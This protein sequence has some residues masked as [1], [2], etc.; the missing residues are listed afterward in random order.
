LAKWQRIARKTGRIIAIAL[1]AALLLLAAIG[2][3]L[4][5]PAVQQMVAGKITQSLAR[6]LQTPFSIRNIEI[7]FF[8][9]ALLEGVYVE[10]LNGDTLLY[11]GR[12]EAQL[13]LFAPFRRQIE[14][15]SISLN[16]SFFN[17]SRSRDSTYNFQFII[18][19]FSS[20]PQDTSQAPSEWEFGIR[21][22]NITATRFALVDSAGRSSLFARVGDCSATIRQ[23]ALPE[24]QIGIGRFSLKNSSFAYAT[25]PGA[26]GP[27]AAENAGTASRLEFPFTGWQLQAG[28]LEAD[29]LSF[30]YD[31]FSRP[32]GP[33]GQFDPAHL[34]LKDIRLDIR[35]FSWKETGLAASLR[36]L[37]LHEMNGFELQQL[38]AGLHVSPSDITLSQLE[39]QTPGSRLAPSSLT[40]RFPEFASLFGPFQEVSAALSLSPSFFAMEDIRYWS[41]P[42]PYLKAGYSGKARLSGQIRGKVNDMVVSGLYGTLDDVFHFQLDGRVKG[43]PDRAG[44]TF[45]ANIREL[46]A[47]QAGIASATEGLPL[48]SG[49]AK[50][51][52]IRLEGYVGGR[53]DSLVARG[54]SI[55]TD[56]YTAFAGQAT[57]LGLPDIQK[58]RFQVDISEMRSQASELSGFMGGTAPP[59]L[60]ALGKMSYRGAFSGTIYDF[61]LA[62][63]LSSGQG[64]LEQDVR[65]HFN[66]AFSNAS[67][68]GRARLAGFG[69]GAILGDTS[70]FGLATMEL[71]GA[72]SGLSL[73][74]LSAKVSATVESITFKQYTYRDIRAGGD[75]LRRRFAG[76]I[77]VDDPHLRFQFDGLADFNDSI[78]NLDF[79]V[80]LDTA[81]L[82]YLNLYPSALRLST[83]LEARLKG[84]SLDNISGFAALRRLAVADEDQHY[85]ADSI[86]L[87]AYAQPGGGKVLAL[88]S[89]IAEA[90]LEGDYHLGELSGLLIEFADGFF[91]AKRLIQSM[92]E[93]DSVVASPQ[94]AGQDFQ[95]SASLSRPARLMR[96]LLPALQVLDTASFQGQFN[97]EN[98]RLQL[99]GQ[100]PRL[101]YSGFQVD[102][103][104]LLVDGAPDGLA[105]RLSFRNLQNEGQELLPYGEAGIRMFQDSLLFKLDI[106]DDTSGQKLGLQGVVAAPGER[107]HLKLLGPMVLNGFDWGIPENNDI[108]FAPA[109]LN[110]QGLKFTRDEQQ[111]QIQSRGTGAEEDFAPIDIFFDEFRLVELSRLAGLDENFL[112][113]ALN[114]KASLSRPDTTYEYEARLEIRQMMLDSQLL[115]NLALHAVPDVN[116]QEL[117]LDVQLSGPGNAFSLAGS[118]GMQDKQLGF[119]LK[120][121]RL[122]M[123]LADL[124][125]GGFA[126]D[127]RGALSGALEIGGTAGKPVVTGAISLDSVSTFVEYLQSRY[128]IPKHTIHLREK[129]IDIGK[130]ELL[131]PSNRKAALSGQAT[132][133]HFDE[134]GLNLQFSAPAFQVL[135]TGPGDNELFYGKILVSIDARI[136]GPLSSPAIEVN[137]QTL[138]GT[139]LT[140]LP[141]SEEEAITQEDF[142]L[143]GKP[144]AEAGDTAQTQVYRTAVSGYELN[145]QLTLTPDAEL[146]AIIDPATGDKLT[147]RGRANLAVEMDKS[148]LL[149]TTGD[150]Y[151][152]GGSYFFNYEGLVKRTFQIREGSHI[153]LP[154]DPLEARFGITAQYTARTSAYELI[155]RQSDLSAEEANAA[156][157]RMDVQVIM[158]LEGTLSEPKIT[159]DIQ[160]PEAQASAIAVA[161]EN[162]LAQLRENGNELNKQVFGLLLFN[163]F[164]AEESGGATLAAAGENFALSSV[165]NLLTNQLNRL[166]D[167]YVKGFDLEI[168]LDSYRAQAGEG[169][170]STVTDLGLGLSK[171]LFNERL[172][173][174]VGGNVG[175]GEQSGQQEAAAVTSEFLLEY[176]LAEDG[177]YRVRV[178][179][180]PDYDIIKASNTIRTGVSILYKKSFGGMPSLGDTTKTEKQ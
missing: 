38:A 175:L 74:S 34:H 142:I 22:I 150:I 14:V 76:R 46:S 127:S 109:Y 159:F 21:K 77:N 15:K 8:N 160:L 33:Y 108:A 132:H 129:A 84:N 58:A 71:E 180:R 3:V 110:I 144:G 176:K 126:S 16:D 137:T 178:F 145:L 125:A 146:I 147:A 122:Q 2:I 154:G 4:Q 96:I 82:D 47:S 89:D 24:Q 149:S 63:L 138:P 117:E 83:L 18:D 19:A 1:S 93:A 30:S 69:L 43:L 130:M 51:G 135:D 114:G 170:A 7:R 12:L 133:K 55:R 70:A 31:D 37:A 163:S 52:A 121:Q 9:R 102:S 39:M 56:G 103:L 32:P 65:L 66:P 152:T 118:Y 72:G 151:I 104:Q 166:A 177:R 79:S 111:L 100:V 112:S 90:R 157:R 162:K 75:I 106:R 171:Q 59:A 80:Q 155:S 87:R 139:Q 67:Y 20:G 148:G 136:S 92:A 113:G 115:G 26:A 50:L 101:Q 164:L 140:A 5:R 86:T 158:A 27:L 119:K 124:F 6:H 40:L 23:L 141:L 42:L 10:D 64:Q 167:R 54:L 161:V 134:I 168:G 78:P 85:F 13:S 97:S 165:S 153:F 143:Y 36:S 173:I 172:S 169:P 44:L 94:F 156:K 17:L 107:F 25:W 41:G 57:A 29:G 48:P 91:P 131:D 99:A 98:R 95:F 61:H 62:G 68:E 45:E 60:A 174:K 81:E 35:S 105:S 179:R 11:A 88:Q 49:L 73:D 28:Q 128:L 116:R 120:V 53:I 123:S